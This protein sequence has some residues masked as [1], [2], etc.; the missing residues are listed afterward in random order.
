MHLEAETAIKQYAEYLRTET[1]TTGID[2][3]GRN[4]NGVGRTHFP[5]THWTCLDI[6]EGDDV[7]IVTDARTWR[8]PGAHHAYDI[9]LSTELFEHAEGWPLILQTAAWVLKPGGWLIITCASHLR[10]PHGAW[11]DTHPAPGEWYEGVHPD[12]LTQATTAAGITI[13]HEHG[14]TTPGDCYLLG[15]KPL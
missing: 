13:I 9:A 11:G 3:G 5:N 2:I 1:L 15:R 4:T 7:D 14:N 12:K 10:P 6:R 8:D